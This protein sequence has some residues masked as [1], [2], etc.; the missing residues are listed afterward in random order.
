LKPN[1]IADN[2]ISAP[3]RRVPN[4]CVDTPVHVGFHPARPFWKPNPPTL[5]PL[6]PSRSA[7]HRSESPSPLSS[8][9]P[10]LKPLPYPMST[11]PPSHIVGLPN[12]PC[13]TAR[14]PAV[15]AHKV[16]GG[17]SRWTSTTR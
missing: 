1:T 9:P 14:T 16:F 17:L 5:H 11:P 12:L 8:C 3:S 2:L 15:T 13:P 10:T 6:C 4:G 7:S